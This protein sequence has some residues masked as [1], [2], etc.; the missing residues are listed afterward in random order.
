MLATPGAYRT[1]GRDVQKE[2]QRVIKK[3]QK[4]QGSVRARDK[5]FNKVEGGGQKRPT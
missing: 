5:R 3:Q 2:N 1:S 4:S